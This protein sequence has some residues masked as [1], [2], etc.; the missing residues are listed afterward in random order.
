MFHVAFKVW[1]ETGGP[2][3]PRVEL[4]EGEEAEAQFADIMLTRRAIRFLDIWGYLHPDAVME[5]FGLKAHLYQT[6]VDLIDALDVG[7][8]TGEDQLLPPFLKKGLDG[9]WRV[10]DQDRY[11]QSLAQLKIR[12]FPPEGRAAAQRQATVNYEA[13]V[14]DR[15]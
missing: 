15:P 6:V 8:A 13:W 4:F 5:G 11:L 10:V 1:V 3:K 2:D 12:P 9:K 14:S 7:R